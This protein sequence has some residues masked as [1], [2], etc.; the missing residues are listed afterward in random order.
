MSIIN[1]KLVSI[2]PVVLASTCFA[3]DDTSFNAALARLR[4]NPSNYSWLQ[5][6]SMEDVNFAN[7][8]LCTIK[9]SRTDDYAMVG[10][11]PYVIAIQE[12]SCDKD[13]NIKS[14]VAESGASSETRY[15]YAVADSQFDAASNSLN[16][17]F[18]MPPTETELEEARADSRR[19]LKYTHAKV[20][21]SLALP[22]SDVGFEE[23]TWVHLPVDANTGLET[24]NNFA[25][26]LGYGAMRPVSDGNGG[27]TISHVNFYK[28]YWNPTGF[29]KWMNLARTGGRG[30]VSL[31]GTVSAG[32]WDSSLQKDV[33]IPYNLNANDTEFVR[34]R[35]NSSSNTWGAPICFDRTTVK[36]NTWN[37]NLYDEAGK[38]I[39]ITSNVDV[40]YTGT[41]NKAYRGNY[42][43][44]GLWLPDAAQAEIA[45]AGSAN[46]TVQ[47]QAGVKKSGVVKVNHSSLR[48]I[49]NTQ[50]SL[51]DLDSVILNYWKCPSGGTCSSVQIAWDKTQQKFV[52]VNNGVITSNSVVAYSD[53][54]NGDLWVNTS[55]GITYIVRGVWANV[56]GTWKADWANNL[57]NSTKATSRIERKLTASE[58]TALNGVALSCIGNC[59]MWDNAGTT[60]KTYNAGKQFISGAAVN[61]DGSTGSA[62][63]Y[64]YTFNAT[65][66][67]LVND[68]QSS[69]PLEYTAFK[70][71]T[72][73]TSKSA[74]SGPLIPTSV[75]TLAVL[76]KAAKC[77]ANDA[78]ANTTSVC[79]WNYENTLSEYYIWR[80]GERQWE[81]D[82]RL[83]VNGE[84]PQLDDRLRV[85]FTCPA[86]REG[87][88][89][90]AKFSL[91]YN[92]PG[93]LWGV[94]N[95]CVNAENYL[96][97]C[98]S[99]TKNQQWI[100]KFNLT[101]SP[102]DTNKT[103]DFVLDASG[104]K[105]F[106]LPQGSGE[107]YP[108]KNSCTLTLGTPKSQVNVA[109]IFSATKVDLSPI[110][111]DLTTT[112]VKVRDG[113]YVSQ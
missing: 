98:T 48:K 49:T 47:D 107:F 93:R 23:V 16:I 112:D 10:K 9:K 79:P 86:N 75:K 66:G 113:E 56:G 88:D 13:Q 38:Q 19:F 45:Q 90:G 12:G 69:A 102:V 57:S 46:V 26:S 58:L 54:P 82:W 34:S 78:D 87:C 40:N 50:T 44:D 85:S 11:G 91:D 8:V 31:V 28:S 4:S 108:Q 111:L 94:P 60:I 74:Q 104:K 70:A 37:Y 67:K 97:A 2:L 1:K 109:D 43:N 63:G 59:P 42:S 92:G 76:S 61:Q 36:Y 22:A 68:A 64:T 51:S 101:G 84:A 17:K 30:Q 29:T 53:L 27:F 15:A 103:T 33:P 5:E 77:N 55:T 3:S 62:F 106:I 35:Y 71:S 41:G 105:Y 20:K 110:P 14:A 21:I 39:N 72:V 100:N 95:K 96:E 24:S 99:A 52:N 83:T 32:E 25:D 89:A 81:K 65:T 80:S 6:R 73:T 7:M 18:W